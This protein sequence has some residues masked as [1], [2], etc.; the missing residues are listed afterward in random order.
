MQDYQTF[1]FTEDYKRESILLESASC[2]STERLLESRVHTGLVP[3]PGSI[4]DAENT[5]YR[6]VLI[7]SQR[8]MV[9][10]RTLA[11]SAVTPFVT[12]G[13]GELPRCRGLNLINV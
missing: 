3:Y 6:A 5:W 4:R 7:Q 1:H 2:T 10:H 9:S 12:Y 13:T 11:H 8:D